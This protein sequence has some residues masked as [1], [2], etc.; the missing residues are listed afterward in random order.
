MVK[1]TGQLL[2]EIKTK[3][4]HFEI[5]LFGDKARYENC[6]TFQD[7][8]GLNNYIS[9]LAE[10]YALFKSPQTDIE[11]HKLLRNT[12]LIESCLNKDDSTSHINVK[13][14]Q[15]NQLLSELAIMNIQFLRLATT[16]QFA[17][18]Q[19]IGIINSY[20]KPNKGTL[21]VTGKYSWTV[22]IKKVVGSMDIGVIKPGHYDHF[23]SETQITQAWGIRNN[24]FAY[25]SVLKIQ[26]TYLLRFIL[27]FAAI[28]GP[29]Q[30]S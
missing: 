16:I 29:Q 10:N 30:K 17:R 24:G 23:N 4:N 2:A 22:L 25:P 3:L 27:H 11:L 28:Q 15:I 9:E 8:I 26:R 20:Y 18:G 13:I 5:D 12:E 21:L 6:S 7:C 1:D 19:N 14:N